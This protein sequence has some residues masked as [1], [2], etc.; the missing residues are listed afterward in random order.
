MRQRIEQLP[1]ISGD[2]S[3]DDDDDD[4]DDDDDDDGGILRCF[5]SLSLAHT[6]AIHTHSFLWSRNLKKLLIFFPFLYFCCCCWPGAG[7]RRTFSLP[8]RNTPLRGYTHTR[9]VHFFSPV[10]IVCL[11]SVFFLLQPP[12]SISHRNIGKLFSNAI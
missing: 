6:F 10:L 8:K 1:K 11:F 12:S 4:H 5:R 9:R 2:D 7:F 3:D